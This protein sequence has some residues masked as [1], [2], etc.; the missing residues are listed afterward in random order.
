MIPQT[1]VDKAMSYTEYRLLIDSL[2]EQNKT[3]GTDQSDDMIHY[4]K[5]NQQRMQRH[6]KNI[7]ISDELKSTISSINKKIIFLVLTEGWCGDAAQNVPLFHFIEKHSSNIELKLLLRDENLDIMNQYLT[8]GS[9]SIPKLICL[10]KDSLK[11]LFV[12]GPRPAP[13]QQLMLN[14]KANNASKKERGE[15]VHLWYARDK[16]QTLQKEITELLAGF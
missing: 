15:A 2:L 7:V 4:A 14:L 6:E 5:L 13:C 3:T 16:T 1:S 12:W 9:K 11:E 8:D 10:E